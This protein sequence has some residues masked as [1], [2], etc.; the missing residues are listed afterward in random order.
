[1][2]YVEK[3]TSVQDG[4]PVELFQFTDGM[5]FWRYCT[6][7]EIVPYLGNQYAPATIVRGATE[8]S[9]DFGKTQMQ[10]TIPHDLPIAKF[11]AV[12]MPNNFIGITLFRTHIG[13]TEF[14]T[15]W[16]GRVVS[17]SWRDHQCTLTC[18]PVFTSLRR[19]GL[20]SLYQRGCRHAVY[21]PGCG[22]DKSL[23]A[24]AT[25][26]DTAVKNQVFVTAAAGF[27]NDHFTGGM[28]KTDE[29][30]RLII[31]HIGN[32]LTLVTPIDGLVGGKAITIY[33]GCNHTFLTCKAKFDNAINFGGQPWLPRKNPF[34]GDAIA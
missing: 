31:Q 3:D 15:H 18:E 7:E 9:Q 6:G 13:D 25:V 26:V 22:V 5:Q 4:R 17:A 28:L 34:S 32:S 21:S 1:M 14:V 29:G 10:V 16:R 33:P 2:S 27:P 12:Q 20:R 30:S 8:A 24:L 19:S 11:L 23:H